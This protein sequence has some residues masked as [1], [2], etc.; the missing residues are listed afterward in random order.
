MG[1]NQSSKASTASNRQHDHQ[2]PRRFSFGSHQRS[3]SSASSR[4]K[5]LAQS[6]RMKFKSRSKNIDFTTQL[7]ANNNL[8]GSLRQ[9]NNNQVSAQ[10]RDEPMANNGRANYVTKQQLAKSPKQRP[11][12]FANPLLAMDPARQRPRNENNNYGFVSAAAGAATTTSANNYFPNRANELA[13]MMSRRQVGNVVDDFNG[14]FSNG[15][16]AFQSDQAQAQHP[17][18]SSKAVNAKTSALVG[19]DSVLADG[20][21][22][23]MPSGFTGRNSSAPGNQFYY[24]QR[25]YQ[26]YQLCSPPHQA[27]YANQSLQAHPQ[28]AQFYPLESDRY[29]QHAADHELAG[30]LYAVYPSSPLD[31]HQASL[32]Q[33]DRFQLS[34]SQTLEVRKKNPLSPLASLFTNNSNSKHS[35]T[36]HLGRRHQRQADRL[37]FSNSLKRIKSSPLSA[38]QA[39]YEAMRTIDMY[40]IRQIARSCMVS[41][42]SLHPR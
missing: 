28:S 32:Q 41:S 42:S 30:Q 6:L 19:G 9:Q 40:M 35:N 25:P 14:S 31:F 27:A 38:Q 5:K 2:L 13:P 24:Q 22:V 4:H 34:K 11:A 20:N 23:A 29:S 15:H 26:H 7:D 16:G 8:G 18:R 10:K 37:S 12:L 1:A 3:V 33:N 17:L 21:V 36:I 39:S